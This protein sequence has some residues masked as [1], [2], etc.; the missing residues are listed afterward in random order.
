MPASD[1]MCPTY[2]TFDIKNE[3]FPGENFKLC[4]LILSKTN[5]KRSTC[6]SYV[7]E[8]TI[9]SSMKI[10]HMCRCNS[11]KHSILDCLAGDRYFSVIDMKSGFHQVEILKEHKE[12]TAFTVGP[13]GLYEY[14]MMPFGLSNYPE[15]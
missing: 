9:T 14:N 4:S 6:S 8:K 2:L 11:D 3:H 12:R 7:L 5:F 10:Q 13:L 1:T 15:T